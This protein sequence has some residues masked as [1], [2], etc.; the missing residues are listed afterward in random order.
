MCRQRLGSCRLVPCADCCCVVQATCHSL[1]C[2]RRI[3][4]VKV[5]RV[6]ACVWSRRKYF[7][8]LCM[9][10]TYFLGKA[11]DSTPQLPSAKRKPL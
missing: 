9:R 1:R 2:R 10:Y 6:C 5:A 3:G 7:C 4:L 8:V 11:I